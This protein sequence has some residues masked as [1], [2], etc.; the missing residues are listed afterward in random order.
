MIKC[1]ADNITGN[2]CDPYGLLRESLYV[3]ILRT[4][5]EAHNVPVTSLAH[6]DS[7]A[8]RTSL[9]YFFILFSIIVPVVAVFNCQGSNLVGCSKGYE[10][11]MH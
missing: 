3:F 10:V 1:L 11:G 8:T 2:S 4:P 9:V 7:I 6:P 5:S